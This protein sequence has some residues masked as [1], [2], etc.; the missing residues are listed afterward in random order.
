MSMTSYRYDNGSKLYLTLCRQLLDAGEKVT[1]RGMA[2]RELRS[3]QLEITSPAEVHVLQTARKPS[4]RIAATEAMHLIGGISSLEQL[5]LASGGRFSQ[6]ADGGRL[7]GA[8]GPRAY[9]QLL[10]AERLLRDDPG[11]RQAVVAI[12]K[13]DEAAIASRDVPCTT[14]LHFFI[15]DGRL[16]LDASM[17]SN[18]ILLGFP[19]DIMVFSCLQHVMAASLGVPA[20]SY[21]HHAASLHAYEADLDRLRLIVREGL[22]EEATGMTQIP[23]PVPYSFLES[24]FQVSFSFMAQKA[25]ELCLRA[26]DSRHH[27]NEWLCQRVPCL[28]P[29]WGACPLCRYT[30]KEDEGCLECSITGT[31]PSYPSGPAVM[32]A[33]EL[34]PYLGQYVAVRDERVIASAA[35]IT[36]VITS[37]RERGIAAH[38]VFRV[39]E[40]EE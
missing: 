15:R 33:E 21:R 25:R 22:S 2:T 37:L 12:W 6:F 3:A 40:G 18:D 31:R 27:G 4:L 19:I 24:D 7:R 17:R 30:V 34:R 11:T 13:G 38:A 32:P 5:N 39:P 35:D 28:G 36:G 16:E 29:G 20:G 1:A 26:D 9:L 10:T 23:L 8:Y 14:S